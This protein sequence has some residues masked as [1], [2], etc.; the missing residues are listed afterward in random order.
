MKLTQGALRAGGLAL[1]KRAHG[2]TLQAA[3]LSQGKGRGGEGVPGPAWWW[4]AMGDEP[5]V[6]R[7][8]C[9]AKAPGA[10]EVM[11]WSLGRPGEAGGRRG[12]TGGREMTQEAAAA[13]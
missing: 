2:Q 8:E 3:G 13:A 12:A 5:A 4:E 1:T 6:A 11:A 10:A 7:P 9:L